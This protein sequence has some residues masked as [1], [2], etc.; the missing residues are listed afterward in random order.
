[1]SS[2]AAGIL[3]NFTLRNQPLLTEPPLSRNKKPAVLE[4]IAA[5]L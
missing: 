1:V 2:S 4:E 3:A 5:G